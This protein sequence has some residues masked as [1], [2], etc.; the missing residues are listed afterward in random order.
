MVVPLRKARRGSSERF[1]P[2]AMKY[3]KAFVARHMTAAE[4]IV[5]S[6]LNEFIWSRG[7]RNPPRRVQVKSTKKDGKAYVELAT[8]AEA[9]WKVF[10]GE[11]KEEKGKKKETKK[12]EEPKKP[13]KEK[14]KAKKPKSKPKAKKKKPK[15][16]PKKKPAKKPAKKAKAKKSVKKK[17][18]AK[19]A[20]KK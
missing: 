4:T 7:A 5:G 18:S 14:P 6:E 13:E 20:K 10:I 8:V 2:K 19:K 15:E 17:S 11:K 16:K 3:L 9:D 1:A 12:K